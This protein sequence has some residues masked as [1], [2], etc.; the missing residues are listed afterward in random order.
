MNGNVLLTGGHHEDVGR[1]SKAEL[2]DPATGAFGYTMSM[3]FPRDLHTA[4]RLAS[5][6]VLIAG[7]ESFGDC[8]S[9]GCAIFSVTGAEVYDV[10]GIAWT[11]V[12]PMK[13]P[14]ETHRDTL[15]KDG[16][17]LITGGLTFK[18]GL[19]RP[20]EFTI[21]NSAELYTERP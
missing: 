13:V 7:G 9:T 21:L 6:K 16:R 14:R 18:G 19:N 20:V 11:A 1:F 8:D 5:G 4:T 10:N 2:Y 12:G 3:P 15:L 17:V